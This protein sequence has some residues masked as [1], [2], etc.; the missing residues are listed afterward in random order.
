MVG[1]GVGA[2]VGTQ[3][4]AGIWVGAEVLLPLVGASTSL[5]SSVE[6]ELQKKLRFVYESAIAD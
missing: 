1:K 6:R 2:E 3:K 4:M 5:S